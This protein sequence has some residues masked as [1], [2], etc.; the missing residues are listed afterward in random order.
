MKRLFAFLTALML[1]PVLFPLRSLADNGGIS[2]LKITGQPQNAAGKVGE[3]VT[4]TVE[5]SGDGLTYRW[6][7]QKPSDVGWENSSMPGSKTKMLS[8]SVM[9]YTPSGTRYRCMITDRY[10][11]ARVSSVATLTVTGS[12]NTASALKITGQPKDVTGKVGET[13]TFT[14]EADGDGL[15]WQWQIKRPTAADW[16]DSSMPG[17]RTGT[18]SVSVMRYTLS[19]TRYRCKI[20]DRYG[21]EVIS[22]PAALTVRE[23]AGKEAQPPRQDMD[24]VWAIRAVICD[25]VKT[26]NYRAAF[27]EREID[28]IHVL[29]AKLPTML[30]TLSDGKLCAKI[31]GVKEFE[32][33]TSISGPEG[34]L[35]L[36]EDIPLEEIVTG[37]TTLLMIFAPLSTH[38]LMNWLGIGGMTHTFNGQTFY[39]TQ[40][41]S[42]IMPGMRTWKRN[43]IKYE[44]ES[45]ALVHEILHCVETNST[46]NG[47]TGFQPLHDAEENGYNDLAGWFDWYSDLMTDSLKSGK[48]GFHD[49]SFLVTHGGQR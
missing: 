6:Q 12:G 11:K 38:P 35:V 36:E 4:F 10:G 29:L 2:P 23:A 19:G 24:N 44:L 28:N 9:K 13:V 40:F 30:K 49:V 43:G 5:A 46:N 26:S 7:I 47:W 21:D 41:S 16:T 45:S 37:D 20:R 25:S 32:A 31:V 14:V 48:P 8:V 3:T 34:S 18:L 42:S 27:K 33:I 22:D 15:T 39:V 1:L 17:C